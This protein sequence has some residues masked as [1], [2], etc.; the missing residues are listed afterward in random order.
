MILKLVKEMTGEEFIQLLEKEYRSLDNLKRLIERDP[1]NALY[2]LDLDDWKYHLEHPDE[3]VKQ[4][5]TLF[6]KDLKIELSDLELLDV[7]RKEH[8]NSIRALAKAINKDYKTVQPKIHKLAEGGLVKF[9]EGPKKNMKKPV[10][11]YNK[12]EIEV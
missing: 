8:P 10:V 9:E 11:N 12:I 7:I 1:E 4:S 2:Q 3:I 6:V 5:Q